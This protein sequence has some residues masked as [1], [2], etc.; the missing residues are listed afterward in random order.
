MTK[1]KMFHPIVIKFCLLG[2]LDRFMLIYSVYIMF[3]A[4]IGLTPSMIGITLALY[5]VAKIFSDPI[6]GSFADKYGRKLVIIIGFCLKAIGVLLWILVP[7]IPSAI[8]GV[9]LIGLGKAGTNNIES[10]MYDEFKFNKIDE[11]FRNTIALKS[12][13]TNLSA[14][15]GGYVTSILYKFGG[16]NAVF[17][18]SVLIITIVSIPYICF[19]LK[20]GMEYT[21]NN[22]KKNLLEVVKNSISYLNQR[23]IVAISVILVSIFYSGYIVFTDTNKMIMNEIGFTPDF[24]AKIYAVAHLSPAITTIIFLIFRPGILIRAI[25]IITTTVWIGI[26][27]SAIIFYGNATISAILIYLLLFPIFDACI[28]DNLH[29]LISDSSLRST[30]MSFSHFISSIINIIASLTIGFVAQKYSYSISISV[31]SFLICGLI[32]FV[33]L[34]QRFVVF[35][36]RI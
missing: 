20:D 14:S 27:V 13:L 1:S 5:E 22:R 15:L 36:K 35:G 29:R 11:K 16:F 10:Y 26:G 34:V 6:F 4:K 3:F 9:M 17:L 18:C 19:A 32:F 25:I 31:F 7:G 28:R 21:I 24:I 2:A 23:K 12:I 8:F 30:I 33:M